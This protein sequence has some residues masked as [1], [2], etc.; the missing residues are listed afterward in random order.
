MKIQLGKRLVGDGEP[1]Y[2]VGEIGINHSGSLD[3][4]KRLIDAAAAAG[5][6][7]VKFQKRTVE[8]VYGRAPYPPGYLDQPRSHPLGGEQ[9]Q[10]GQKLALEFDRTAWEIL[11]MH[12]RAQGLDFTASC[13]DEQ[14]LA[15][16]CE[17]VDPPWIKVASP[18]TKDGPLL[19][20][21]CETGKPLVVSTG[22][23]DAD[24]VLELYGNLRALKSVRNKP[25]E[26]VEPEESWVL[27]HCCSTYPAPDEHL[28]LKAICAMRS[29][30]RCLVGYSGHERGIATTVAAMVWGACVVERHLTLDRTM[31]GSDQAA[32]LEPGGFARMVRD[33]RSVEAA[34][35]DGDKRPMPGEAEVMAKLRRVA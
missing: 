14:A 7:A 29:N 33:I 31:Y 9:T 21:H 2:I 25:D 16:V 20:A 17:W 12:A 35:G 27:L 22:G 26:W 11:A 10:R 4:A 6:D 28:N 15:D 8:T 18:S 3:T 5:A 30:L 34:L 32:S 19:R 1:C 23:M 24:D 13:W